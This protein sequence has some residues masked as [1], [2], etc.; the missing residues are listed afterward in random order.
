MTDHPK[1]IIRKINELIDLVA[2][3][4][5]IEKIAKLK[6]IRLLLGLKLDFL[7]FLAERKIVET[8]TEKKEIVRAVGKR[9]KT[10]EKEK[11]I[12]KFIEEKGGRA[13]MRD[14]AVLNISGRSLRR[15]L[16]ALR[17]RGLIEVEKKGREHF[18]K[19]I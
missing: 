12:L 14:L 1:K 10:E 8:G 6:I 13:G 2:V 4:P 5:K 19:L 15:Y 18:Y 7:R 17:R 3:D 9:E 16:K 11:S